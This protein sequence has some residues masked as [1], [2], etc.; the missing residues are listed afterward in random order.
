MTARECPSSSPDR[1]QTGYLALEADAMPDAPISTR[2][3]F[4]VEN[5]QPGAKCL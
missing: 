4:V 2:A 3:S 5:G 1:W